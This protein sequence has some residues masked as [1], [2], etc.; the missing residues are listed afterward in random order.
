MVEA[1]LGTA[2]IEY[3]QTVHDMKMGD[4][5]IVTHDNHYKGIILFKAEPTWVVSIE[6]PNGARWPS[7]SPCQ[8][9][10]LIPGEQVVLTV[11]KL[12]V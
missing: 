11:K 10:I 1:R 3:Q 9:R 6:D 8:V 4:L 12:G 5:A 2:N 7:S